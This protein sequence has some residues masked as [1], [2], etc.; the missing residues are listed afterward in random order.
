MVSGIVSGF[1]EVSPPPGVSTL[2][3]TTL[4][5]SA[6]VEACFQVERHGSPLPQQSWQAHKAEKQFTFNLHVR[7]WMTAVL[8]KNG[9][10]TGESNSI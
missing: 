9:Q 3:Q 2:A 1:N 4:A 6:T 5:W 10:P 7:N 8:N